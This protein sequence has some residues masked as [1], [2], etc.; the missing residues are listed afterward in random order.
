[1]KKILSIIFFLGSI[2]LFQG[3]KDFLEPEV[4]TDILLDK[5]GNTP[6]E[7][8]LLLTQAYVD[9][10]DDNVTGSVFLAIFHHR[11]FRSARR[12]EFSP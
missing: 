12:Y 8:N 10:R 5:Y 1:M 2:A 6:T 3:C 4:K 11:L 9:L 7:A